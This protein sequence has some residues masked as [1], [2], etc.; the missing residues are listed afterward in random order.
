MAE[1]SVT[2]RYCAQ[3]NKDNAKSTA[4]KIFAKI[5]IKELSKYIG[6]KDGI[7]GVWRTT[8]KS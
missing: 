1:E 4:S 2:E 3:S 7:L 6:K 5:K 8:G